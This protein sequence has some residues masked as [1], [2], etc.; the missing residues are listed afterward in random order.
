MFRI[1][2][3]ECV[4]IVWGWLRGIVGGGREIFDRFTV[5]FGKFY[6]VE[7]SG[8]M[9]GDPKMGKENYCIM[10]KQYCFDKRSSRK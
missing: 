5:K 3:I 6:I 9:S 1:W 7:I 8:K 2:G 10:I 4:C